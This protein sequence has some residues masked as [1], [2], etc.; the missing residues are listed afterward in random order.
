MGAGK[1]Y[2][3]LHFAHYIPTK[4]FITNVLYRHVPQWSLK[5][6][7]KKE[8]LNFTATPVHTAQVGV[9]TQLKSYLQPL[10]PSEE[11]KKDILLWPMEIEGKK[12]HW[13]SF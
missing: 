8:G 13:D 1:S 2:V 7:Q 5:H 12:F 10:M 3:S 6:T 4:S 9:P 11:I